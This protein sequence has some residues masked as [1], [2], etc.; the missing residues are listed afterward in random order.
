MSKAKPLLQTSERAFRFFTLFRMTIEIVKSD[1]R[2]ILRRC[3]H[4][5]YV[6]VDT[7]LFLFVGVLATTINKRGFLLLVQLFFQAFSTE[8]I[9][10]IER[11]SAQ[12]CYMGASMVDVFFKLASKY[13]RLW[14]NIVW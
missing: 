5:L 12:Y 3:A 11:K 13:R 10:N 4:R 14:A 1:W 7:H 8:I 2:E 6:G 9:K